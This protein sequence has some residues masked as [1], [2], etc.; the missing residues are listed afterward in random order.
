[1]DQP[2]T[3][4][5][6]PHRSPRPQFHIGAVFPQTEIGSDPAGLHDFAQAAESLGFSH[7]LAYDHVVGAHPRALGDRT[8]P[9]SHESAFHEPLTL[10][11]L[12]AGCTSRIGLMTGV[13]IAPQRQ[14]VL[15]AKQAANVD[16]YSQG[17][18]RLGLGVGYLAHEY[19][20]LGIDFHA[21]GAR[22]EEQIGLLRR[23]WSEPLV[24]HR[25]PWET[26]VDAGL[27][28]LPVQRPLPIYVGGASPAAL[29]RAARLGDGYLAVMTPPDASA[30]LDT[31]AGALAQSG[32]DPESLPVQNVMMIGDTLDGRRRTWDEAAEEVALWRAAGLAGI[33]LHTIGLGLAGPDAHIATLRRLADLCGLDGAAPSHW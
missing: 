27:N 12:L 2:E 25:G 10:F 14:T 28:P 15:L 8:V 7:I 3:D 16:V 21:R 18:L 32:R 13:I 31:L 20:A 24:T 4:V 23:L 5:L 9:Y 29:K 11:S 1:M 30:V 22:F 33:S 17:R 19:D 6:A 26:I